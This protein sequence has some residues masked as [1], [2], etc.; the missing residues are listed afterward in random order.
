MLKENTNRYIY[1]LDGLRAFAVLSVIAYHLEWKW[2]S[3]GLLGVTMFFV[4]SGYLITNLLL[5][6]WEKNQSI[7]LKQFW[8]RRFRRLLPGM[9][10]MM[11]LV[12]AW[13]TI[14]DQSLLVK[15]REDFLAASVYISNWWYIFQ[16]L[17][18]FESM[19]TPSL[20]THFWSLAVE[21]QFYIVWPLILTIALSCKFSRKSILSYTLIL[22]T[23]SASAMAILYSP[24]V[25]P[26]RVYYGTDTRAFSLLMG[27]AL[28]F[29]W[30]SHKLNKPI[31]NSVRFKMDLM[32]VL[33]LGALVFMM[34]YTTQYD[35]FLYRGG[36]VFASF[37]TAVLVAVI[38]HPASYLSRLLSFKPFVWIG[39]RSYGIYLWHFPVIILT[40]PTIDTG[41]GH[42]GRICFQLILTFL[43]AALSYKY[44]E[45]PI[46][47][48]AIGRFIIKVKEGKWKLKQVSRL[49]LISLASAVLIVCISTI[50]L[51]AS[52]NE[53]V[54]SLEFAG[55]VEQAEQTVTEEQSVVTEDEE[56]VAEENQA[57]DGTEEPV[58]ESV[59]EETNTQ[60]EEQGI[61]PRPEY[62]VTVIGDSV[63]VSVENTLK[64]Y[65]P[66]AVIDASVGRQLYKSNDLVSS[67]K[68]SGQLGEHVVIGL[69]TNGSFNTKQLHS[70]IET[71]GFEKKIYLINTRVPKP[72]ESM[73]N[74]TLEK[75]VANNPSIKLIDW[76][77]TSRN[78][79][80]YFVSDGV[81]LT[82]EGIRVYA[83]MIADTIE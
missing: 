51:A 63:M 42:L 5:I 67:L 33:S 74:E 24:E 21:E 38:V 70:L 27:A 12:T 4:L 35:A 48:G 80:E 79:N 46:R 68:Q 75:Y 82:K 73:V 19:G 53:P 77:E 3:G 54:D 6:E 9:F 8:I 43:L 60:S 57:E 62:S 49:R 25:D 56:I 72:W 66:S 39:A 22:A 61:Q 20:L 11:F 34:M 26:T 83:K 36:M 69:G 44:I 32:G 59:E 81:H 1:G 41:D 7:N 65:F 13:V 78:H 10:T 37:F 55:V 76:Y 45:N 15:L 16:D 47:H 31:S 18:Y 50:G 23:I 28:A 64:E 71:I 2:A 52:P 40:T 30:P 58:G 29:L 14:F 17:S